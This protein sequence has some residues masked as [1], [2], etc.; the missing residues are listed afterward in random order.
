MLGRGDPPLELL[1]SSE[2]DMALG[3]VTSLSS[4]KSEDRYRIVV[5]AGAEITVEQWGNGK[6]T[7]VGESMPGWISTLLCRTNTHPILTLHAH[8]V[9]IMLTC[10]FRR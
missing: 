10:K 5:G 8:Q 1:L 2:K 3:P 7:Q 6:L 4:L 9:F